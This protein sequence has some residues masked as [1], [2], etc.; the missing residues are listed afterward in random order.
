MVRVQP[1]H[2]WLRRLRLVGAPIAPR[3]RLRVHLLHPAGPVIHSLAAGGS[4]VD[5]CTPS[6]RPSAPGYAAAAR[7]TASRGT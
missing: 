6:D 1:L 3:S 7:L 5:D 4:G 2:P